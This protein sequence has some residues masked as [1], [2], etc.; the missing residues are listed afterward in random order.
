METGSSFKVCR[1]CG[2]DPKPL[3]GFYAHPQMSDG[4]LN[5]CKICCDR[6]NE[7]RRKSKDPEQLALKVAAWL[8]ANPDK[9]EKLCKGPCRLVKPLGQFHKS[10]LNKDGRQGECKDCHAVKGAANRLLPG[11]I[12][13][14]RDRLAAW[15]AANPEAWKAARDRAYANSRTNGGAAKSVQARQARV[16][17]AT[18]GLVVKLGDVLERDGMHCFICL[19]PIE[20]K[21]QLTYDH[22]IPLAR[23]GTHSEENLHP[24]HRTCNSWKNNRL[25]EELVGLTPPEP[26]QIT[27]ENAY[28]IQKINQ[29]KSDSHKKRLAEMTPEQK[30]DRQAKISA[31]VTS[32]TIS[33]RKASAQATWANKTPE[34]REAWK[35]RCRAI[36]AGSKG[37]VENLKKG[38]TPEVRAKAIQASAD[39]RRG[40]LETDEHKAA[41]SEGLRLAYA[42]GR[43]KREHTEETKQKISAT[44]LG[45]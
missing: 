18:T 42:E 4:R 7:A 43:H 38:W 33:K 40:V 26:G 8:E 37:N 6:D 23:G 14:E 10:P 12:E 15:R 31:G 19:K 27:P 20:D 39:L 35:A 41:I 25:P 3:E 16:K 45:K 36:K 1:K 21:L 32:E 11:N 24:A 22:T 5:V 28:R 29:A 44:K 34:E 13:R 2:G 9:H 30:A 17:A